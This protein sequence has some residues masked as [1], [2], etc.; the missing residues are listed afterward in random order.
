MECD[1]I[2]KIQNYLLKTEEKIETWTIGDLKDFFIFIF[3]FLLKSETQRVIES[4]VLIKILLIIMG[5]D[6]SPFT[7]SFC[8]YLE[9]NVKTLNIDQWKMFVEFSSNIKH[10]FSN[11]DSNDAWPLIYDSYVE[12]VKR[13]YEMDIIIE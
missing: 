13:N 9:E 2:E 3:K 4:E 10:D 7:N 5:N 6:K 11:Y 12:W 1:S 8:K